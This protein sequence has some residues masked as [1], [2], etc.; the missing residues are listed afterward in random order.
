[1]YLDDQP[2]PVAGVFGGPY[3]LVAP[4]LQKGGAGGD[5]RRVAQASS[6][7]TIEPRRDVGL[8][9]ARERP[10]AGQSGGGPTGGGAAK[11]ARVLPEWGYAHGSGATGKGA[12]KR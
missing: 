12:P 5:A 7:P 6:P 4:A 1:L 10:G 9:V 3:G 2:W 11:K 8:F